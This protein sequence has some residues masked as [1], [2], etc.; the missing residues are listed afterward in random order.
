MKLLVSFC[1]CI[2]L[3]CQP[4]KRNY[5]KVFSGCLLSRQFAFRRKVIESVVFINTI[6]ACYQMERNSSAVTTGWYKELRHLTRA[7]ANTERVQFSVNMNRIIRIV[8]PPH[9]SSY[10]VKIKDYYS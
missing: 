2:L 4:G 5:K 1:H 9:E 3:D 7:Q 6:T 8:L 10:L